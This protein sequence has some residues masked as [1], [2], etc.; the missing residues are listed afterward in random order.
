MD[1]AIRLQSTEIHVGESEVLV[2]ARP[3]ALMGEAWERAAGQKPADVRLFIHHPSGRTAV[4]Q[5]GSHAPTSVP[6]ISAISTVSGSTSPRPSD[7]HV[8]HRDIV[9][10]ALKLMEQQLNGPGRDVALP[11]C[12]NSPDPPTNSPR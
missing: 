7:R 8:H 6:K 2:V 12:A 11:R 4:Y 5:L 10:T 9:R 1:T 3:G